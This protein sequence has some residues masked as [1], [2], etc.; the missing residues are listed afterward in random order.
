MSSG[1]FGAGMAP[2]PMSFFFTSGSCIASA[3]AC[4]TYDTIGAGVLAGA[5]NAYQLSAC[6]LG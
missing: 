1:E 5:S 4:D 2:E 6:V 3:M